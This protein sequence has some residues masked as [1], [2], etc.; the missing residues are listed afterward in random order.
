MLK[1]L[2]PRVVASLACVIASLACLVLAGSL[3]FAPHRIADVAQGLAP[4]LALLGVAGIWVSYFAERQASKDL[5]R[6][7]HNHFSIVSAVTQAGIRN[8]YYHD[9]RVRHPEPGAA[10]QREDPEFRSRVC[11]ELSG[12]QSEVRI[13]AIAAREFFHQ[14]QG[15]AFDTVQDL[16]H[17]VGLR[18]LLL[19][20]WCE[21]AVSRALRESKIVNAFAR[22]RDSRLY[23]DVLASCA[24]VLT[25]FSGK[26]I[27]VRLYK[28]SSAMWFLAVGDLAFV[29]QYHYGTGGRASGKVPLVELNAGTTYC[30]ELEGHFEHLWELSAPWALDKKLLDRLTTPDLDGA[31]WQHFTESVRY[32]RP[33]LFSETAAVGAH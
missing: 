10:T 29:E 11:S 31:E 25:D 28:S 7:V 23:T 6:D 13:L 19:H 5:M 15:F 8:V 21:Y 33:D 16:P 18:V 26:N 17:N 12:A 30:R 24:S 4:G 3:S 22:F 9:V 1:E 14:G 32:S 20:P 2:L 27:Q